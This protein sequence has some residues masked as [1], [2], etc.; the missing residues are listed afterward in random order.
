MLL[1]KLNVTNARG[2]SLDLPLED[3]SGGFV[4]Q[5]IEG[6]GPV[7]A[8]LVSSSFANMDGEQ[9]H[10]SRREARNIVVKLGLAPDYASYSVQDLRSQLYDFFM[11]KTQAL[12]R[13][14]LF[15]RHATNYLDQT[16][17]LEIKGRIE[18]FETALFTREPTVD[19]SLL[20][21]DP[22]FIDPNPVIFEGSTVSDLTETVLTYDGMIETGVKFTLMPDRDI[23]EFTIYHRPPDETLNTVYFSYP[24][25]AGDR[26]EISSVLGN[27]YVTLTRGGVESSILYSVSPQ[28]NWLEI[29]PGDNVFRVYTEGAAIPFEIEYTKKY[30][31]L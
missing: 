23:P 26:V 24:L 10:S 27:K 12:L 31:G 1:K 16:L 6:L 11:P 7:K 2:A 15:D 21:Y 17:D 25:L 22:D 4:V 18:S 30:G 3:V 20:C 14:H 29:F 19:L 28:S 13:F 9:Y 5:E 8:N